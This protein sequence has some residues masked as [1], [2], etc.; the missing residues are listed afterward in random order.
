MSANRTTKSLDALSA[1][2]NRAL[3]G[4]RAP[5]VTSARRTHLRQDAAPAAAARIATKTEVV[6]SR[7]RTNLLIGTL[8]RL[9]RP[10]T[11]W[12]ASRGSSAV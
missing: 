8:D 10:S 9:R 1:S 4:V 7:R 6:A 3:A 5:Q 11:G 12:R 2:L